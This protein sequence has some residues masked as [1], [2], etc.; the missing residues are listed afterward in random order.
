[1]KNDERGVCAGTLNTFMFNSEERLGCRRCATHPPPFSLLSLSLVSAT[2][3]EGD[4]RDT[5]ARDAPAFRR[6]PAPSPVTMRDLSHTS[7]SSSTLPMLE[8]ESTVNLS[9]RVKTD[10]SE[11]AYYLSFFC[12]MLLNKEP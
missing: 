1:M 11:D 10:R 5:Q 12:D 9:P 3:D 8:A 4:G 6:S 7:Y 2:R